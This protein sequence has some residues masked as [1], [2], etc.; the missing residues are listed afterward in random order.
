[1]LCRR[2]PWDNWDTTC[3]R[4][5]ELVFEVIS[6]PPALYHLNAVCVFLAYTSKGKLPLK[7]FLLT[8]YMLKV[9]ISIHLHLLSPLV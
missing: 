9:S 5:V 7:V 2:S 6:A 4:S 8:H 3:L 1:M